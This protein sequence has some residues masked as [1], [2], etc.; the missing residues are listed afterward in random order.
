MAG[1][2]VSSDMEYLSVVRVQDYQLRLQ[3]GRELRGRVSVSKTM[4]LSAVTALITIPFAKESAAVKR[5]LVLQ[6][7]K[8]IQVYIRVI[9]IFPVVRFTICYTKSVIYIM[10]LDIIKE[11]TATAAK[12]NGV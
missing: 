5:G 9:N 2:A 7:Q 12:F 10:S 1:L 3:Q 11:T 6:Y 4:S 8:G